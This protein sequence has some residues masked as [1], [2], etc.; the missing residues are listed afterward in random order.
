M[1]ATTQEQKTVAVELKGASAPGE[2][3]A[4][5]STF[6][7]I[8]SDGDVT[9]PTAFEHGSEVIIGAFG[10]RT[11]EPPIGKGRIRVSPTNATV[12]GRLFLDTSHGRDAYNTLKEL[13]PLGSW[14]YVFAVLAESRGDFKG[15]RVRFLEK[16]KVFSVDPVLAGAGVGTF[17]TSIKCA[18]CAEKSQCPASAPSDL[19]SAVAEARQT[20]EKYDARAAL[21]DAAETVARLER[22]VEIEPDQVGWQQRHTVLDA[23]YHSA[24]ILLIPEAKARYF[25]T[26]PSGDPLIWGRSTPYGKEIWIKDR[27]GE[28]E[29]YEVACHEMAH[30]AG[31]GEGEAREFGQLMIERRLAIRGAKQAYGAQF[32]PPP[33]IVRFEGWDPAG[34]REHIAY[35]ESETEKFRR[36]AYALR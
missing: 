17:T 30:V 5:F 4:I 14:S 11:S 35:L 18:N 33:K 28:R 20:M 32:G 29:A 21:R 1:I 15:K 26:G 25:R 10:H 34:V 2:L 8:D 22:D 16:V 6:N 13:G 9:L 27:L 24:S 19:A 36:R 12:E 31:M 3:T 23:I 7:V